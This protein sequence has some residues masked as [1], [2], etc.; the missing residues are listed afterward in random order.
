MGKHCGFKAYQAS[1]T[2]RFL[3]RE[4]QEARPQVAAFLQWLEA[5]TANLAAFA[6]SLEFVDAADVV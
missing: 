3:C 5:E 4:G 6:E 1:F 2:D